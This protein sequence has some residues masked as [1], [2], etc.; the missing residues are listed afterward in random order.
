MER[1]Q[2]LVFFGT[3]EFAV[4]TLEALVKADRTP[5]LVVTQPPRPAG[6][7][8]FLRQ[9]PVATFA[10]GHGIPL[11]QPK[12][13]R[14]KSFLESLE[15]LKPDLAVVVAFGQIFPPRLLA[16]PEHG[17][18]NVHA[19][20]LPAYRGAAPIQGAL[21]AGDARAGVTTMQMDEGLDTGP[22]LLRESL[23]IGPRETAGELAPRLAALGGELLIRT[24]QE[25]EAGILTSVP[26][27][28]GPVSY[29]SRIA[30]EDGRVDWTLP[31]ED[32]FNRWRAFSPWPGLTTTLAGSS[33]KLLAVE[34]AEEASPGQA[35]TPGPTPEPGTFLGLVDG[36]LRVACGNGS[37]LA[38]KEVQKAGRR[39]LGAASFANGERLAAGARFD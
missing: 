14:R 13:V 38:L 1:L 36:S 29:A 30:K 33:V 31:A 28:E 22:M 10:D 18:V 34:L 19:S 32:L 35:R 2:R 6:R 4:P 15:A 24:L 26:Q 7:G 21:L 37:V 9:P 5:I 20:L 11:L 39:A 27:P 17:C 12:R 16:M 8:R 3:P 25:L 23:D